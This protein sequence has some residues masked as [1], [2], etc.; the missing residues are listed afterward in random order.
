VG[1]REVLAAIWKGA[2]SFGLVSIPVQ[3]VSAVSAEHRVKFHQ[4][5]QAD[6]GRVRY[7]KVCEID[8]QELT[9]DQITRG[10]WSP[11]GRVARV[12]DK[13]LAD[14]PLPSARALEVHGF[15][16]ADQVS[17]VQLGKPY[18]L[19]PEETG[20]KAYTLL[21]EALERSGKAAVVKQALRGRE[22]LAM[23]HPYRGLL[24]LR[25]LHWPDE[26]QPS[27]KLA[28]P[29]HVTV[30]DAELDAADALMDAIGPA[31]LAGERD[32][33]AEAVE[34]V[35]EAKLAGAPPP[36]TTPV[37]QEP[38][39]DLMTALRASLN[40]AGRSPKATNARKSTVRP[41]HGRSGSVGSP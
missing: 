34:Q 33:Y 25:Q 38:T 13:D 30:S 1:G 21:R 40:R 16:L 27:E 8:G 10:Y 31:D 9:D 29:E 5:H 11:D 17:P 20:L 6:H 32:H 37:P 36:E 3:M 24:L 35:V 4:L 14:L 12:A 15:L 41:P 26:V 19:R 23:V 39:V 2:I 22:I 7:R 18:Y 28:P